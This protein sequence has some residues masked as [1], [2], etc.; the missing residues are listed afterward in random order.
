MILKLTIAGWRFTWSMAP[1][2]KV[3]GVNS[4]LPNGNHV[5]MWDFDESTLNY[6]TEALLHIQHI[7]A[8]PN[9]YILETKAKENYIAYCFM[10]NSWR[11][12]VEIIATTKGVDWNYF[13]YGVYR[14]K[15]T[16]RVSSKCGR[17]PRLI[18]TLQSEIPENCSIRELRSWVKYETLADNATTKKLELKV[19]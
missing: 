12:T 16:L 2:T 6:V 8:L 3:V 18:W 10:Q 17:K 1:V 5:L 4:N 11:K 15:F 7:Y 14:G 13:K 19:L 9:I